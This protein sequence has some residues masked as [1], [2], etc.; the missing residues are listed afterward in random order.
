MP[1]SRHDQIL[2]ATP[3]HWRPADLRAEALETN[4]SSSRYFGSRNFA[5]WRLNNTNLPELSHR[6]PSSSKVP[7]I[8]AFEVKRH[9][10]G[11]GAG[12][13][14]TCT[15]RS[16]VGTQPVGPYNVKAGGGNA[17]LKYSSENTS[18]GLSSLKS[19]H[20]CHCP[21]PW[22]SPNMLFS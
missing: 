6:T 2:T 14:R 20:P 11:P 15:D 22:G 9:I 19:S 5:V 8:S 10:S 17:S 18:T 13:P 7:S 3:S 12:L 1:L 21:P 4:H 16:R